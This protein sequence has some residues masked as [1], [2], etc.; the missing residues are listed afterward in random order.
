MLQKLVIF[1]DSISTTQIGDGG[2]QAF[3]QPLLPGV[4]IL[5]HAVAESGAASGT[6][7]PVLQVLQRQ[8]GDLA[9]A[10]AVIL[11]H[12]TNDWYWG[13]PLG[14]PGRPDPSTYLGALEL[15]GREIFRL[16]PQA[17]LLFATPLFRWQAPD[18]GTTPGDARRLPNRQGLTLQAYDQAVRTAAARL[19]AVLVQTGAQSGFGPDT[20]AQYQP[21]GVHPNRAGCARLAKI[22]WQALQTEVL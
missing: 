2:Y 3:L 13:S 17:T 12:G 6:P 4:T 9:G 11:W 18:G 19:G 8:S 22:F 5:N 15:A 20:L 10:G 16:A 21:D 14:T 7:N 1:G